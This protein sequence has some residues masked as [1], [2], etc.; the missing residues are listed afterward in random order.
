MI[1]LTERHS[2]LVDESYFTARLPSG[3]TAYVFPKKG[4]QRKTA[5]FG[6][7][8][9]SIDND[10]RQGGKAFSMPH[11]IAHF[12]EHQLFKKEK[13]DLLVEFSK[14]GASSNAGTEFQTARAH[15]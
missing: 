14:K 6:T 11:G 2:P 12:L 3:L 1:T 4:M 10:F 9:G 15:R 5:V 8:Y 13:G 7:L